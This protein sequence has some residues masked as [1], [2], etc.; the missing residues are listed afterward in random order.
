[1]TEGEEAAE[2]MAD[3]YQL[4]AADKAR[5][6]DDK[7]PDAQSCHRVGEMRSRQIR[8]LTVLPPDFSAKVASNSGVRR[9]SVWT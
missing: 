6:Y 8:F 2:A 3:D 5:E 7:R 4:E 9:S 1:M